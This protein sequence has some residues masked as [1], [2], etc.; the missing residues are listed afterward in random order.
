MRGKAL[1][2]LP[3]K[4]MLESARKIN[5]PGRRSSLVERSLP[6]TSSTDWRPITGTA[7]IQSPHLLSYE[8]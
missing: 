3:R 7:M 6:D 4:K 2:A 5:F 8:K 1:R